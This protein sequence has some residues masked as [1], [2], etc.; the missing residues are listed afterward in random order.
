MTMK[1]RD[2]HAVLFAAVTNAVLLAIAGFTVGLIPTIGLLLVYD[3][4]LLT[5]PRM[6]RIIRRASGRNVARISYYRN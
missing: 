3:V 6:L 2:F 5:R 4:V 1:P